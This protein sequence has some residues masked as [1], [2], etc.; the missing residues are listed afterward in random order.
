M[1]D[2]SHEAGKNVRCRY[3]DAG[4]CR[5]GERCKFAHCGEGGNYAGREEA[6]STVMPAIMNASNAIMGA[7]NT[8]MEVVPSNL[9]Q[10]PAPPRLIDGHLRELLSLPDRTQ[11]FAMNHFP[12]TRADPA[13]PLPP[14]KQS[15]ISWLICTAELDSF[16]AGAVCVAHGMRP[17]VLNMANGYNCGGA[18][19]DKKG[20]QEESLFRTSTLPLSLWPHRRVN[21]KRLSQYDDKLPRAAVA[22][23]PWSEAAVAYSPTVLLTRT[24]DG[25]QRRADERVKLAVVSA[26]AQDLRKNCRHARP[27]AKFD[28]TLTREIARSVLWAAAHH[29]HDSIVLGALGCGAFQNEPADVAHVFKELLLPPHGEFAHRFKVVVFAIIFSS[30]NVEAFARH[31]PL[32]GSLDTALANA[33]Q[34]QKQG[35]R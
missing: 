1:K 23:Y 14:L 12:F 4:Y 33:E 17:A 32:V 27:D 3:F 21:D 28:P 30:R 15:A 34:K 9:W 18:W 16:A 26:A 22:T 19:C 24:E 2:P 13:P 11:Y 7:V 31:F 29:G 10:A 35:A 6:A 5:N 25:I 8:L 20:S